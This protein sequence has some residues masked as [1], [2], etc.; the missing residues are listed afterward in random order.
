[1]ERRKIAL[2]REYLKI[3]YSTLI[4]NRVFADFNNFEL[5]K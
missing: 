1:M 3:I 5:A 2:A 4:D